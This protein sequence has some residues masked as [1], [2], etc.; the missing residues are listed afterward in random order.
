MLLYRASLVDPADPDNSGALVTT[1]DGRQLDLF[2]D[3]LLEELRGQLKPRLRNQPIFPVHLSSAFDSAHI[4]LVTTHALDKLSGL[5]GADVEPRRFR[6]NLVVNTTGGGLPDEQ[7][8][9][10]SQVVIGDGDSATIVAITKGDPRCMMPN[11]HPDTAVQDP[12]VLRTIA[13]KQNNIM[14]IYGCV[15]KRGTIRLGDR[16]RLCRILNS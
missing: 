3:E 2:S 5:V 13:Q 11:L 14:G 4:S 1:P 9:V 12:R 10:G 16:V 15:V 8:W 6:A 7:A